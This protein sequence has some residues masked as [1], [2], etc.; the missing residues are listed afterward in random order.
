[1]YNFRQYAHFLSPFNDSHEFKSIHGEWIGSVK[2]A[3][4]SFLSKQLDAV[5]DTSSF[6]I[7]RCQSA[8]NEMRLALNALLKVNI[9]GGAYIIYPFFYD[10]VT[11]LD[12]FIGLYIM[13]F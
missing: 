1:M 7:E 3:L 8:R 10:L 6:T 13:F 5:S 2:P 11:R 12:L 9:L 4:S